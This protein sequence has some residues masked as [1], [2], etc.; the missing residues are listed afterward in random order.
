MLV[1]Y[2]IVLK[3]L[4]LHLFIKKGTKHSGGVM[5]MVGKHLKATKT[6]I[7]LENTL[8]SDVY[9]LSEQIR[10]IEI[11]WPD[12]QVRNLNDLRPFL[13]KGTVVNDRIRSS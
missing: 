5:I 7:D 13:V 9:G 12:G 1:N 4:I 2:R 11:D 6:D 8:I 10:I 3:S